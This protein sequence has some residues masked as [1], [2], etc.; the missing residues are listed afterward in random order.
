M[1]TK[2]YSIS[3]ESPEEGVRKVVRELVPEFKDLQ[4][5]DINIE[6]LSGGI[7]NILFRVSSKKVPERDGEVPVVLRIY[8]NNTEAIIDRKKE[9]KIHR[10]VSNC[11]LGSKL[12]GSFKNGF[13]HGFI[14]GSF[15]EEKE[16]DDLR[17]VQLIAAE[18][19]K[20]HALEYP[21][22]KEPTMWN[23]I[24]SFASKAPSSS[25][26]PKKD[27]LLKDL[28]VE[29]MRKEIDFLETRLEKIHSPVVFCHN[30]LLLKNIIK[31]K[32]DSISFIDFEYASYN[33]RGF[34]IGNHFNEHAGMG[35]DYNLYP[36]KD[37][38][39]VFFK[40]YLKSANVEAT[41]E[42]LHKLY[43]E[44]NQYALASHLFWGFWALV[45]YINSD[46][47]FDFLEYGVARLQQY[48]LVK[49][50]YLSIQ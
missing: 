40:S 31:N 23:T 21:E 47:D 43:V 42:N 12:Y 4:D 13:V 1:P 8:G 5:S 34:D 45:Q 50:E 39:Y 41:E 38:Q 2:D 16:L 14:A 25:E 24:R 44:A 15:V 9:L 46:I 10:E 18:L 22:S 7:T 35:P 49:D 6:T 36:K 27:K 28:D 19:A 11:G 30:D 48:L 37:K 20:W 33:P 17:V 3:R 32:R 29:K 26:D